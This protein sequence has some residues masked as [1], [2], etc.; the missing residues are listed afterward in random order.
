M[1]RSAIEASTAISVCLEETIPFV[2]ESFGPK[3]LDLQRVTGV[4][5]VAAPE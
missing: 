4:E 3:G 2:T 1:K 5:P